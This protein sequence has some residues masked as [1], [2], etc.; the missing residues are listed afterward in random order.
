MAV[1]IKIGV[2]FTS[3]VLSYV[4]LHFHADYYYVLVGLQTEPLC[5]G[6]DVP[7]L[8]ADPLRPYD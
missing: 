6:N 4:T 1:W 8:N 7:P 2:H 5:A 3:N